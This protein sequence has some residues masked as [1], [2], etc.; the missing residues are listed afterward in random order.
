[1]ANGDGSDRRIVI[2]E[3]SK[4]PRNITKEFIIDSKVKYYSNESAWMTRK[5]FVEILT[6]FRQ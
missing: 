3:K 2:I 1:M 4:N 5:I 6:R